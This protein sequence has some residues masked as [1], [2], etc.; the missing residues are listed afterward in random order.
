M[1][2]RPIETSSYQ[3]T[4]SDKVVDYSSNPN[5]DLDL[6]VGRLAFLRQLRWGTGSPNQKLDQIDGK[7]LNHESNE[8]RESIGQVPMR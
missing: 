3:G 8:F 6:V 2:F 7:K 1:F 5:G 4:T